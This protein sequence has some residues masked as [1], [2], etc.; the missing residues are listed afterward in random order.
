LDPN[1]NEL[2]KR[3]STGNGIAM[4]EWLD[5]IKSLEPR[6]EFLQKLCFAAPQQ[7]KL[8]LRV[9]AHPFQQVIEIEMSQHQG[10]LKEIFTSRPLYRESLHIEANGVMK[11]EATYFDLV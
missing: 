9:S 3:V 8:E 11:R 6:L 4:K 5:S 2:A 1:F 7:S 10:S